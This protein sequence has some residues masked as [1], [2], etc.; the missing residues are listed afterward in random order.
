MLQLRRKIHINSL[1]LYK[2][3]LVITKNQ[4][5]QIKRHLRLRVFE[6]F[7]VS[8]EYTDIH[9]TIQSIRDG[10]GIQLRAVGGGRFAYLCDI[11]GVHGV[12]IYDPSI[13]MIIT[14]L[15][16]EMF[17]EMGKKIQSNT[18]PRGKQYRRKQRKKM[19]KKGKLD[20]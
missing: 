7:G 2:G 19:R 18:A 15:T 16:I 3:R 13:E 5:K 8:I 11:K 17:V 10:K 4:R 1:P 12:W 9:G 14:V 6:R 20:G